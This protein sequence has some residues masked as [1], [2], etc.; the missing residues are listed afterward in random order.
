[1]STLLLAQGIVSVT[2]DPSSQSDIH[3]RA[4]KSKV[5]ETARGTW[6]MSKMVRKSGSM[7]RPRQTA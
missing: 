3:E 1:M 6:V 5:V 4:H 2:K 7:I